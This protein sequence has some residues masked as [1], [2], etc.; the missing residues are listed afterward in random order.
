MEVKI[1]VALNDNDEQER[2]MILALCD[3]V[4]RKVNGQPAMNGTTSAIRTGRTKARSYSQPEPKQAAAQ[5]HAE[6]KPE[7]QTRA[8]APSDDTAT[9]TTEQSHAEERQEPQTQA[10]SDD[11]TVQDD[12]LDYTRDI[13]PL[14]IKLVHVTSQEFVMNFLKTKFGISSAIQ[15]KKDEYR[16]AKLM[17]EEAINM[18][19]T[20]E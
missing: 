12:E 4:S 9:M 8:Q 1:S 5:P 19:T 2:D 13:R 10:P 20:G 7:P 15:L 6:E 17:L 11:T 18:N 3:L 14:V 16:A